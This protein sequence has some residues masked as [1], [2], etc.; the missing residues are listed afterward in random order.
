MAKNLSAMRETWVQSLGWE[1]P[2]RRAWQPT[3]V[4]FPG[5]SPWTEEPGGL[6]LMGSHRVGHD[7]ATK[8]STSVRGRTGSRPKNPPD[9]NPERFRAAV[10]EGKLAETWLVQ[11]VNA[12]PMLSSTGPHV[13]TDLI[14]D[15]L[16]LLDPDKPWFVRNRICFHADPAISSH[17]VQHIRMNLFF[18]FFLN[19]I[20]W[21]D[22][23]SYFTGVVVLTET[24]ITCLRHIIQEAPKKSISC[25]KYV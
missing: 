17:H 20:M 21:K 25:L 11:V 18:F 3:P 1:G 10:W 19:C 12:L 5:E 2:W 13:T 9:L 24:C 7:W 14:R 15:A 4:L 6:Q 16:E 23:Q 8:H 22:D